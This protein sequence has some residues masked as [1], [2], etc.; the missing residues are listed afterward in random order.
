MSTTAAAAL[1]TTPPSTGVASSADRSDEEDGADTAGA[2]LAS[3]ISVDDSS[4]DIQPSSATVAG[5]PGPSRW[6]LVLAVVAL[7]SIGLAVL[8]IRLRWTDKLDRVV[9]SVAKRPA[10]RTATTASGP[11]PLADLRTARYYDV[12]DASGQP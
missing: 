10:L 9:G 4:P 7:G 8:G 5:T 12:P 2:E 1:S 6:P 11:S 3:L